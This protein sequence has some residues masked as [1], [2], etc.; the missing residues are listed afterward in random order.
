M[1]VLPMRPLTPAEKQRR[2]RQRKKARAVTHEKPVERVT[3]AD[4]MAIIG[5][6]E[7]GRVTAADVE[8]T[9]KLLGCLVRML[10]KDG[11]IGSAAARMNRHLLR[12]AGYDNV[13]GAQ[14]EGAGLFR[15]HFAKALGI[16]R[17]SAY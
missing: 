8:L 7:A 12:P 17:A 13:R 4:I 11:T 15:R 3:T 10:P 16:G 5:R 9:T 6:I 1:T 2:Y 14:N